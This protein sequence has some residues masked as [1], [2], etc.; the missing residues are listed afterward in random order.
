MAI[1]AVV[2]VIVRFC[3]N[4]FV[5]KVE[6]RLDD[7]LLLATMLSCLPSAF[8][9]VYGLAANGLGKDIWVLSATEITNV[10]FYFYL[11]AWMYFMEATLVK[12]TIISFYLRIFPARPTRRLLWG[13]FIFTTLFGLAY[14]I[15]SLFQCRPIYYFWTKW[16][17]LHDGH[18]LDINA[19]AWS[20]AAINIALDLWVLAIPL[21]ELRTLQ[22][23]WKKK[24]GVALMFCVGTL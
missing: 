8:I 1:I 22:L 21:W 4:I 5:L 6:L 23:H 3:Y 10:L 2:F 24:I 16:D 20:N 11:M 17:G 13:T 9:S 7:W 12:L 18:C 19:V 15:A 14:I